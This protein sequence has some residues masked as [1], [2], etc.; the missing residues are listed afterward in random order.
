VSL[1]HERE[2]VEQL[3][4]FVAELRRERVR[5]F[6][7]STEM[8]AEFRSQI[9]NDVLYS[10]TVLLNASLRYQTSFNVPYA[11]VA[12]FDFGGTGG[13]IFSNTL[14]QTESA[15]SIPTGTG[16]YHMPV[17]CCMGVPMVGRDLSISGLTSGPVGLLVMTK[18]M[19]PFTALI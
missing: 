19:Q 1:A 5:L 11:F 10:G 2:V 14:N 12:V 17:R 15:T 16:T 6:D 9:K 18:P 7:Q 8:L 4:S 3:A 13:L